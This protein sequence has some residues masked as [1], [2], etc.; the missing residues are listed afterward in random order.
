MI[1][2]GN[3]AVFW[4]VAILTFWFTLSFMG[5]PKLVD[6]WFIEKSVWVW[7]SVIC[8]LHF[9]VILFLYYRDYKYTDLI[10]LSVLLVWGFI[11]FDSHWVWLFKQ[12]DPERVVRYYQAFDFWYILPKPEGRIVPDAYHTILHFLLLGT[13]GVWLRKVILRLR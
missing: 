12:P 2:Q 10:L 13:F 1:P 7:I 8:W 6:S 9:P 3:R 11:Q 5:F 4:S